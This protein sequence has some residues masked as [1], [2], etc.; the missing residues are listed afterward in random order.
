MSGF[1]LLEASAYI[2]IG[3]AAISDRWGAERQN[4]GNGSK[5]TFS[6]LSQNYQNVGSQL[7]VY[8]SS[9]C[10]AIL[11]SQGSVPF[12]HLNEECK[13]NAVIM[14]IIILT[15]LYSEFQ[16]IFV[17]QPTTFTVLVNSQCFHNLVS[18][19]KAVKKT[20]PHCT[21][22]AQHQT[23]DSHSEQLVNTVVFGST[24]AQELALLPNSKKDS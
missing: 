11:T 18:S 1:V 15:K 9:R 22:S 2:L 23:A 5:C 8:I 7:P 21:L 13:F 19:E 3:K 12:G 4:H 20:N 24:V 16:V 10:R 6:L 14:T 17:V